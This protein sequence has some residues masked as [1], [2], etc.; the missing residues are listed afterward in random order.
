[1]IVTNKQKFI[2]NIYEVS[3]GNRISSTMNYQNYQHLVFEITGKLN[4]SSVC[5]ITIQELFGIIK[6]LHGPNKIILL[7]LQE[8]TGILGSLIHAI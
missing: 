8:F 1:M 3:S 5:G 7:Y 6:W 4:Y 2:V